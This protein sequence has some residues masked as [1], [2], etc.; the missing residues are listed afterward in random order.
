MGYNLWGISGTVVVDGS[1]LEGAG[2]IAVAKDIENFAPPHDYQRVQTG[3]IA[4]FPHR[5]TSSVEEV[6]LLGGE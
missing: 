2:S 5:K 4:V 6:A 3:R 1:V